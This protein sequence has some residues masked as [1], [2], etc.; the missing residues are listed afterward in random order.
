VI[1]ADMQNYDYYTYGDNNGYGQPALS[2]EVQGSIKMAIYTTSQSIQNNINYSNAAYV[3]MTKA[4]VND[5]YVIQYN[6][7][8]LKVLYVQPAGRFKQVY[9]GEM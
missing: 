3:G 1:N 7:K 4:Q 8:K 2:A 5:T 9:L 6:D